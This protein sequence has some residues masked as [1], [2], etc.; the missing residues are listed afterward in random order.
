LKSKTLGWLCVIPV[1]RCVGSLAA[2]WRGGDLPQTGQ[3][4]LGTPD[5]SWQRCT[6]SHISY[7]M[8]KSETAWPGCSKRSRERGELVSRVHAHPLNM[9]K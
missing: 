4:V 3:Q 6:R 1:V 9:P 2:W 5:G 7:S 8:A